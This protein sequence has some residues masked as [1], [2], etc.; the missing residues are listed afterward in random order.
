MKRALCLLTLLLMASACESDTTGTSGGGTG[1]SGGGSSSMSARIDGQS[2]GAASSSID[3]S[4]ISGV[5]TIIGAEAGGA[6]S[7]TITLT[8][9][10]NTVGTY[11]IGAPPV[12]QPATNAFLSAGA[13]QWA[14][15]TSRGSGSITLLSLNGTGASGTFQFTAAPIVGTTAAGDRVVTDGSFNVRF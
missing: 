5:V 9:V 10:A 11:P 15:D 2:W 1:P 3:A 4:N 12:I 14:A 13:A 6:N 8:V 7:R